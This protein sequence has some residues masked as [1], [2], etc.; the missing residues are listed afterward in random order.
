MEVHLT[1]EQETK[2]AEIATVTGKQPETLAQQA[3]VQLLDENDRFQR[4]VERGFA[5]LD[6]GKFVEPEDVWDRIEHLLES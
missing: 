2:L 5:S 6:A 3:I 4:A 1:P